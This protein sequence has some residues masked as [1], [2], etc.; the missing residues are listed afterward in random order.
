MKKISIIIPVY[1]NQDSLSELVNRINLV[2]KKLKEIVFEIIIVNDASTDGSLDV[3]RN[4]K[5]K[6]R[7]DI[8]IINLNKNYGSNL[9]AKTGFKYSTGDAHTVLVADLQDP[10]ELLIE[11]ID[12]WLKG[13]KIVIAERNSRDD[14]VISTF[15]SKVFY[16]FLRLL[17]NK[18]YPKNGF[19]LF[20]IDKKITEYFKNSDKDVYFPIHL[21]S[22]GFSYSVVKYHRQKRQAGKSQWSFL[23]KI[24]ATLEIFLVYSS[25]RISKLILYLGLL[26]F[27]AGL[28]YSIV[29]LYLA[30]FH[31]YRTGGFVTLF[32]YITVF[33]GIFIS[34]M[35][36]ISMQ[37]YRV[38]DRAS[39]TEETII[40]FIE[41]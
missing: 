40:D 24:N 33:F 21:M 14:P 37:I 35:G 30:I 31:G 8:I 2:E 28:L 1:N 23:K 29:L 17:V 18:N 16:F 22:L 6:I 7:N 32:L 20:L 19:D 25:F 3:I 39:K 12:K 4:I 36:I 15:F 13:E 38:L 10:P 41:K 11:L 26:I 9:T 34:L 27:I 5:K